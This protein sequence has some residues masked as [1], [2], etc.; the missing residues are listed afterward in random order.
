VTS[1][2][3]RKSIDTVAILEAAKGVLVLLAGC[4]LLGLLHKDAHAVAAEVVA[5][6]HLNPAQR[7]PKVFINLS[8]NITNGRL[9]FIAG[10]AVV[11]AAFRLVEAWGLWK[12]R[13]WAEWLAL[14]SGA[15]YLPIEVYEIHVKVSVLRVLALVVNLLVVGIMALVLRQRMKRAR[16]R[17]PVR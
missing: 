11:Y 8:E 9:W 10:M 3:L 14:G 7:Y 6:L 16:G 15:I 4:G 2:R 12:E 5:R 1:S 13:G 17:P